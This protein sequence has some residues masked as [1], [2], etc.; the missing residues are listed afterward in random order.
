[1]GDGNKLHN[2]EFHKLDAAVIMA[3]HVARTGEITNSNNILI[4]KH[5]AKQSLGTPTNRGRELSI[6][7]LLDEP[8]Y[9]N[10]RSESL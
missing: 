7:T 4:V 5:E 3:G 8:R 10:V 2:A 6:R 9:E 1:M